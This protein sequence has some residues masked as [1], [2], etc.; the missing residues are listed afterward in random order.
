MALGRL[1]LDD[2]AMST[3]STL[4][5]PSGPPA[6]APAAAFPPATPVLTARWLGLLG[7]GL[8]ALASLIVGFGGRELLG[9]YGP[10]AGLAGAA[11]SSCFASMRMRSS[12]P[13]VGAV[14][15]H[16]ARLVAAIAGAAAVAGA[17][18]WTAVPASAGVA[19]AAASIGWSLGGR[20]G[21]AALRTVAVGAIAMS[22]A[23]VT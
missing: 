2:G 16:L 20:W 9:A 19:A 7:G 14:L 23:A 8:V 4:P 13:V 22:L 11:V 12:A 15:A 21:V 18:S 17:T 3:A 5:P 6:P 1:V 10:A